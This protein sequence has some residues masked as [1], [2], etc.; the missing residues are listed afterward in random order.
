MT[1][2]DMPRILSHEGM[3]FEY[4]FCFGDSLHVYKNNGRIITV[5]DGVI[6]HDYSGPGT[7]KIVNKS[8]FT[9]HQI[10]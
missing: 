9:L 8:A 5:Q 3:Q 10:D 2:E 4:S 6:I 1:D 7:L